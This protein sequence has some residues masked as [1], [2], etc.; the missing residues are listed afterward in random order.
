[1]ADLTNHDPDQPQPTCEKRHDNVAYEVRESVSPPSLEIYDHLEHLQGVEK[2]KGEVAAL[3]AGISPL[4]S[5]H[6]IIVHVFSARLGSLDRS[7]RKH[8][9]QDGQQLICI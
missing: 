3:P 9:F 7:L 4:E 2:I 1:M 6:L 5:I 8:N